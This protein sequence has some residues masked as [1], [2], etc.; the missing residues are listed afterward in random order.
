MTGMAAARANGE[1]LSMFE[2]QIDRGV[3]KTLAISL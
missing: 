3:S 1:N 2:S